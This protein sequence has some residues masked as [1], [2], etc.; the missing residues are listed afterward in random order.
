VAWLPAWGASLAA[1]SLS[2]VYH[3]RG[4]LGAGAPASSSSSSAAAVA[5]RAA[6]GSAAPP[7]LVALLPPRL[8]GG[9]AALVQAARASLRH[10]LLWEGL[11][12]AVAGLV[13]A[14]G[15]VWTLSVTGAAP[16]TDWGAG[17]G[18]AEPGGAEALA[19]AA[20]AGAGASAT[21][22]PPSGRSGP[23][24]VLLRR[25]GAQRTRGGWAGRAAA[26]RVAAAAAAAEASAAAAGAPDAAVPRLPA[27][28]PASSPPRSAIF[29]PPR[30][31]LPASA[32]AG[33]PATAA[34]AAAAAAALLLRRGPPR[35]L[36]TVA[37][38]VSFAFLV[39]AWGVHV[40]LHLSEA[41]SYSIARHLA[42]C[43]GLGGG[44]LGLWGAWAAAPCVARL[45]GRGGGGFERGGGGDDGG[46]GREP[47]KR[48]PPQRDPRLLLCLT[49]IQ[50]AAS[51]EILDFPP[52]LGGT[53]DAH[54]CWHAATALA[55]RLLHGFVAG[56]VEA[57]LEAAAVAERGDSVDGSEGV[58]GGYKN[59]AGVEWAG[60]GFRGFDGLGDGCGGEGSGGAVESGGCG[61]GEGRSGTEVGPLALGVDE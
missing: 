40:R 52:V 25:G 46:D 31:S 19:V 27:S 50:A 1:W 47:D 43:L 58:G 2:A 15:L 9:A 59:D 16:W 38:V 48:Q 49:W 36:P 29:L 54:A 60:S 55:P 18:W 11:D 26:E 42:W 17:G 13:P 3:T 22:V 7:A 32:P 10:P 14:L 28:P 33:D 12:T 53:L 45:R 20:A 44:Q 23:T 41:G 35:P 39:V 30:S 24:E 34:A 57:Y 8:V 61:G 56:D 5:A 6:L 51:L 21:G 37:L 4:S